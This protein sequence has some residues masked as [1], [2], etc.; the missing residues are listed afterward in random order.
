MGRG[1]CV[2]S[3]EMGVIWVYK[4]AL[5]I[6]VQLGF[7]IAYRKTPTPLTPHTPSH[8]TSQPGDTHKT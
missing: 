1:R 4:G 3:A 6:D 5:V 7:L 8:P 2:A